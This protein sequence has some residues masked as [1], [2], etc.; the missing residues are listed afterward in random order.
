MNVSGCASVCPYRG[1]L[2]AFWDGEVS[3]E[4]RQRIEAHLSECAACRQDLQELQGLAAALKAYRTP[5]PHRT[6]D[7][8]RPIGAKTP[9]GGV[10][11]RGWS[12]DAEF[13]RSLA[14]QLH[15]RTMAAR[16]LQGRQP[17]PFLAPVGLVVSS[18][19]L[20]GL[21]ALALIAY[22]L[23]QWQLLPASVPAAL[24][25]AGQLVLGPWVWQR[26]QL[27]YS[28]VVILLTPFLVAPGQVWLLALEATT[29]AILL[30]IAALHTGWLLR[31]LRNPPSPALN[32]GWST[33]VQ[34]TMA[35]E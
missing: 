19:A 35:T 12:S 18:L 22:V 6:R 15:P 16:E 31:W 27:L 4:E 1:R 25:P 7:A 8:V 24:V 34:A 17:S 20:R 21:A 10:P 2:E 30:L 11:A 29:S 26:I 33:E 13:W 5:A 32:G 9:D 28:N 3:P 23:Y 14:P